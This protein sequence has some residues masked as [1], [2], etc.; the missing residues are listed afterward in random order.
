MLENERILKFYRVAH[1]LISSH[2]KKLRYNFL[3]TLTKNIRYH[4]EIELNISG[5]ADQ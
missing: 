5:I 1:P 2:S 3:T 4:M